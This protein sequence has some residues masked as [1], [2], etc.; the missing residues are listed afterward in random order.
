MAL[1]VP[2]YFEDNVTQ[3]EV[4]GD[5]AAL[6]KVSEDLLRICCNKHNVKF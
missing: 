6:E 1:N 4:G 5:S 2:A 3:E